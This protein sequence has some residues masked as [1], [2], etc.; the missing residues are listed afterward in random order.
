MNTNKLVTISLAFGLGA[1]AA[2]GG[3]NP[4]A[5]GVF[6]A[7]GFTGRTLRVEVSGDATS[8]K[9]GATV[10]FGTGVTVN[11]V[12]VAS[13][14]DLFAEITVDPAATA[15]S[16]DVTVS[17]GGSF[18]LKQAF[19]LVAPVELVVQGNAGQGGL[20]NF[21]LINHDFDNPFDTTTDSMGAYANL[22]L[23]GPTGVQ[24][25][26]NTVTEYSI[27]GQAF[28]DLDA[29]AGAL[30]LTS[31]PANKTITSNVGAFPV[32]PRTPTPFTGTAT[33]S[34]SSQGDSNLYSLSATGTPSLVHITVSSSDTKAA[35]GAAIFTDNSWKNAVGLH[36]I[37]T[38][39]ATVNFIVADVQGGSGYTYTVSG[40]GEA[41]TSAAY[42]THTT[43]GNTTQS[44]PATALPFRAT[45]VSMTTMNDVDVVSF[46]VTAGQVSA[47]TNHA[48]ILTNTGSDPATDTAVELVDGAQ[49]DY[50]DDG[51]G[52]KVIDGSDCSLFGCSSLGEDVV[53][54][55]LP[56]GTYYLKISA[57]QQYSATHKPYDAVIWLE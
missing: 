52:N 30:T 41:L 19:E 26:M 50:L 9:D 18:T 23:T 45:P 43:Q 10:S 22:L 35:I 46:T 24:F 31:G 28:I 11:S 7:Q 33:G 56:A 27:N 15:G 40:A 13:P 29:S 1:I 55:A 8:W 54:P 2:C 34:I 32:T 36:E 44:L 21:T 4:T 6:P 48:H 57:G 3:T 14:T 12:T 16:R 5:S 47:G 42:G 39:P 38:G 53:S 51:L 25:F 20:P 49:K 17:S 37:L